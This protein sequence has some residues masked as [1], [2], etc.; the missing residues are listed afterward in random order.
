[1]QLSKRLAGSP[2]TEEAIIDEVAD[3][4]VMVFGMRKHFGADAVDARAL[5]KLNRTIDAIR[6]FEQAK[7]ETTHDH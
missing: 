1:M 6:R 3:V 2:T 7:K 4:L 5:Y